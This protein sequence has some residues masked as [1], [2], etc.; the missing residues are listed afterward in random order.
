MFAGLFVCASACVC[1]F[2]DLSG[3]PGISQI[4]LYKFKEMSHRH[5]V[6]HF[7]FLFSKFVL[8]E[9]LPDKQ[10]ETIV[11]M[12]VTSHLSLWI[13]RINDT[14]CAPKSRQQNGGLLYCRCLIKLNSGPHESR[15]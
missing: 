2:P 12:V 8:W 9:Q 13:T 5:T 10:Y 14:Q 1:M 11:T 7:L 6:G 4:K 3:F 15:D